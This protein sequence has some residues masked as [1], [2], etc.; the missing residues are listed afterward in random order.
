MDAF[1]A[2]LDELMGKDRN[3][4]PNEKSK[5]PTHFSH[6]DV[7]RHFLCG[8]GQ[9]DIRFYFLSGFC[10]SELFTNTKNDLGMVARAQSSSIL[11]QELATRN[12]MKLCARCFKRQM[13]ESALRTSAHSCRICRASRLIRTERFGV[14]AK[15]WPLNQE[16]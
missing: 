4:L 8:I 13:L 16:Y 5:R 7:C 14:A 10:P 15:G 11:C 6:P 9:L 2:Q 3:L 1:R 12:T